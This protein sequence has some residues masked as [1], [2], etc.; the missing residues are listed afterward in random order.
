ML[1]LR[2]PESSEACRREFLQLAGLGLAAVAT[3]GLRSG[4]ASAKE[5]LEKIAPSAD[6]VILLWMAGGQA[7]CETWD[8]KKHTPFRKGM[9][10]REIYST[11]ASEPTSVDGVSFSE[12]LKQVGRVMHK[13]TLLRTLQQ[14]DL[15][16][17]LH[18]RHQFHF[19]TCYKPPVP[20][21]APS[22][23][24]F[25]AKTLGSRATDVPAYVDIGQRFDIGEGFEVKAFHSAGFL[26]SAYGP[27]F[28]PEPAKASATVRPPAGMSRRRFDARYQQYQ[29]LMARRAK[30]QDNGFKREELLEAL[31]AAHRLMHSPAAAAFDLDL[32]PREALQVYNT[33]KFGLG[34]LLARRL[35]EAGS[36]F[37]EVAYEYGPFLGW[38]THENGHTRAAAM[39]AEIDGPIAKLIRDL[40]E[41]GLLKRT[42]VVLASEFSR[43]MLVEGK[44]DK[45]VKDQ[46][47]V[48]DVVEEMK[49]YGM[50][51]HFTGGMS[52]LLF[53][54]GMKQGFVYGMTGAEPP[55]TTIAQPVQIEQ[56]HATIYRTLGMPPNLSYIIEGQPYFVTPEGK[57]RPVMDLLS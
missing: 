43:A 19:H 42:L 21:A 31:D 48:P 26:G 56:L 33:G 23:G 32:E 49:Y 16:H 3:G 25:V 30:E 4:P 5:E 11:F 14:G 7:S 8:P 54:G 55:F 51:R 6:A 53:G 37:V 47:V 44:L 39:K 27:F 45:P 24:A 15:G 13:G 34:C 41:R 36:R 22:M 35:I 38:D 18:S 20:I 50:H 9:K 40:D 1:H 46:V 57:G 52:V 17:I 10:S 12:G 28:V 29:K 2:Y